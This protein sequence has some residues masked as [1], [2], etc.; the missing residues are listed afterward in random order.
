MESVVHGIRG[1]HLKWNGYIR[2]NYDILLFGGGV[3]IYGDI[4][5]NIESSKMYS[6]NGIDIISRCH[7]LRRTSTPERTG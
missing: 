4:K 6:N 3:G 7:E 2:D 5:E 1:I